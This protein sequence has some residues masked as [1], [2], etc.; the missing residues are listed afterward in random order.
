MTSRLHAH[1]G[2]LRQLEILL[3]VVREGSVTGAAKALHLTQ[4]TVSMQL[5]KLSEA[6]GM[7]LFD[8][9]GRRI[10]LTDAGR[11]AVES[12]R[13][14]LLSI[15]QLDMKLA[16]MRGLTTGTLRLAVVTTAKYFIPHLLGDFCKLYPGI[17]VDLK[18][19]NRQQIVK[20]LQ[21]GEDDFCVFSH[22]PQNDEYNLIEF[23]PN[24]LVAIASEDHPMSGRS[25]ISLEEFCNEPYIMRESG[26]GTRFAIEQH[27]AKHN[28]ELNVRMTIQS[29]E[30]IK[31]MVMAG[32]GVSILS[33]HTLTFGGSAG[34]SVLKVDKLP[35][36]TNW[37]MANMKT[38]HES[39]VARALL[40]YVM[41]NQESLLLEG[42]D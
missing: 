19:D 39:P 28:C 16:Q 4:P 9:I 41:Q 36:H 26:S 20:R 21:S 22:P 35:I 25:K 38:R 7:P 30:A 13:E 6:I 37:Y 23:L 10:Q 34:L 17:D 12:A 5:K 8:Q 32:M 33:E 11:A 14:V 3:A 27:M 15:E 2:T 31:H 18:V 29:N 1:I 40:D 42:L 24:R